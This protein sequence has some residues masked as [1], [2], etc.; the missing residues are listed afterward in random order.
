[1]L[2]FINRANIFVFDKN[3]K[4]PKS[5]DQDVS[6]KRITQLEKRLTDIQEI[7][8]AI[9]EKMSRVEMQSYAKVEEN[10]KI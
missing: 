4:K 9:D 5:S 1:M 2:K 8:I 3:G 6:G 10:E 7:V